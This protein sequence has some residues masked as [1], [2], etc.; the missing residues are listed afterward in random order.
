MQQ[1]REQ[2]KKYNAIKQKVMFA[3]WFLLIGMIGDVFKNGMK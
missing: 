2:T 3:F 1:E